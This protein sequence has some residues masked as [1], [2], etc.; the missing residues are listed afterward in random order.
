[1]DILTV[2]QRRKNMSNIPSKGTKPEKLVR[3]LLH[4]LGYR[5]KLHSQKLPGTPDII[6]PKFKAVIFIHGCFWHRHEGC[7]YTTNPATNAEKWQKKFQANKDR[8][9]RNTQILEESGWLPIV[10]WECETRH[11]DV[12]T[13]KLDN[14]LRQRLIEIEYARD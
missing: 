8:D 14:L 2:E 6:L 12:I 11:S 1:M 7:K 13:L 10:I 9:I 4:R 3:S 5:F